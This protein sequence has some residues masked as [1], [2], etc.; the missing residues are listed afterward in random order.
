M[1]CAVWCSGAGLLGCALV[2]TIWSRTAEPGPAL[3]DGA[4]KAWR[5]SCCVRA[6]CKINPAKK[7]TYKKMTSLLAKISTIQYRKVTFPPGIHWFSCLSSSLSA[8]SILCCLQSSA[9][10]IHVSTVRS[11]TLRV[12]QG[13]A[14]CSQQLHDAALPLAQLSSSRSHTRGCSSDMARS[15]KAASYLKHCT[16]TGSKVCSVCV[17]YFFFSVQLPYLNAQN[18]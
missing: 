17:G 4:Q 9:L 15:H 5:E 7:S 10:H 14:P 13:R 11:Q 16:L 1:T 3:R 8:L 2:G 18:K 6:T 12:L